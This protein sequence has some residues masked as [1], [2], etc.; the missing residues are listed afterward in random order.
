MD[1]TVCVFC[2]LKCKVCYELMDNCSSCKASGSY[3]SFLF[4]DNSTCLKNCPIG[5]YGNTTDRICYLCDI[6][7]ISCKSKPDYCFECDKSVGFAWN[8]YH[9]YSP[10]PDAM[11][12]TNNDTNCT[13]C[14][15][16]CQLCEGLPTNCSLCQTSGPA[17]SYLLNST[18]YKQCPLKYF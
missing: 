14:D 2:D 15:V 11:F 4:T 8:N 17:K 1:P 9:C 3:A 16:K 12:L 5:Y 6:A 13:S 18:C 10:C 7:C